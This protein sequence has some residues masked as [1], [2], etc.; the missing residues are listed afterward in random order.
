MR[1]LVD[2][3][4]VWMTSE[5]WLFLILV[6]VLLP[7][8]AL[9]QQQR[10]AATADAAGGGALDVPRTRLYASALFTHAVFLVLVWTTARYF[11][12]SLLSAYAPKSSHVA[13]GLA[14]LT[15]GLL[16][17]LPQLQIGNPVG[18]ARA[19]LLAPRTPREFALFGVVCVSAG[20]AEELTYRG[21]LFTLLAALVGGW[22]VPAIASAAVFGVVH[23]FQGWR[24]ASI[25]GLI[26]LRD[27]IVVGL[28][29]TLFVA[30]VIHILHDAITGA[31]ISARVR[32]EP[33]AL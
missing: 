15:L 24:S 22:W 28:T 32:Q 3:A 14:A 17:L 30:I 20:V 6:C 4:Q 13:I 5:A 23:L 16:P 12:T 11:T 33:N 31:V 1:Y 25:A 26:G 27:Q 10:M 9:R 29:G 19:Q 2:P 7:I 18:K 21:V 8:A